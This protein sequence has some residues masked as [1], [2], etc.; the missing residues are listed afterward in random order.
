[1]TKQDAVS[2]DAAEMAATV[3]DA[4]WPTSTDTVTAISA[5][6]SGE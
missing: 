4:V 2:L 3:D 6:V 1:M 5:V